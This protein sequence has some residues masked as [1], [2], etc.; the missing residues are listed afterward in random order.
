MTGCNTK[1]ITICPSNIFFNFASKMKLFTLV[2]IAIALVLYVWSKNECFFLITFIYSLYSP[3]PSQTIAFAAILARILMTINPVLAE[4]NDVN[5]P[6]EV[7]NTGPVVAALLGRDQVT[8]GESTIRKQMDRTT[9]Y[10]SMDV[11]NIIGLVRSSMPGA[12]DVELT[13]MLSLWIWGF[14]VL[15]FISALVLCFWNVTSAWIMSKCQNSVN[16]HTLIWKYK[17]N[18][19]TIINRIKFRKR[20]RVYLIEITAQKKVTGN[21]K[22]CQNNRVSRS[23]ET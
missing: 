14:S 6:D 9:F 8:T 16:I 12:T 10:Y 7:T 20:P 23:M 13:I 2:S 1:L 17:K 18:P 19:D 21:L 5:T 11:K 15:N 4:E 3:H 22:L